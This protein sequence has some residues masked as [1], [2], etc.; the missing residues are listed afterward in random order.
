MLTIALWRDN[1]DAIAI[2]RKTLVIL[3]ATQKYRFDFYLY[4]KFKKKIIRWIIFVPK[5]EK[6]KADISKNYRQVIANLS[7]Y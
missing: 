2:S 3:L 1:N 7:E 4:C 5:I 6:F